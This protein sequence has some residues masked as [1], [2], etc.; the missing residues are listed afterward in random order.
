M[1]S[2]RC[3]I[4]AME[5]ALVFVLLLDVIYDSLE[6]FQSISTRLRSLACV[7]QSSELVLCA[8]IPLGVQFCG[9]CL[10]PHSFSSD[11]R[12]FALA[13]ASP[14][15]WVTGIEWLRELYPFWNTP[16]GSAWS[17]STW[18]GRQFASSHLVWWLPFNDAV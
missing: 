7:T 17:L 14:E 1:G 9:C 4:C 12:V 10:F 3:G 5:K 15:C 2:M 16:V 18:G 8:R 6:V 11:P 13:P